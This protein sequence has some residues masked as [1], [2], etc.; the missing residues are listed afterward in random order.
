MKY[1]FQKKK[2]IILFLCAAAMLIP[3]GLF[4]QDTI[5][6]VG[7]VS[8]EVTVTRP[9]PGE[10]VAASLGMLLD[11]GDTV[12][13]GADSY[14]AIIFQDDGSRVKLGENTQLT[15]NATREK[16]SL[17]KR[18][19]LNVG[20]MWA[21]VTKRRGTDF[22]ISTPTSVASVKGTQFVVQQESPTTVWVTE[23]EVNLASN[24]GGSTTIDAGQKGV[25]GDDGTIQVTEIGDGEVP[26]E[27]GQHT[28]KI[29]LKHEGDDLLQKEVIIEFEQ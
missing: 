5:A 12:R 1:T 7:E 3:A 16:K 2:T 19:R 6:Y 14:T 24:K 23:G 8:G 18:L 25:V 21:K 28:L 9:N 17:K 15:L 29:N 20:K 11:Q 13:T 27:P 10:D 4:A 22:E 26:I